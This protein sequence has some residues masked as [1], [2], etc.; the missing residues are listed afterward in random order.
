MWRRPGRVRSRST[1]RYQRRSLTQA[2]RPLSTPHTSLL[3]ALLTL[4]WSSGALWDLCVVVV[5]VAYASMAMKYE[6]R[7]VAETAAD[8]ARDVLDCW[9]GD[10]LTSDKALAAL[11]ALPNGALPLTLS[12]LNRL[13]D[14]GRP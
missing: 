10:R 3:A 14:Q 6:A 8:I 9:Q 4:F 13:L 5:Q 7:L 2:A 12:H 1:W 11:D